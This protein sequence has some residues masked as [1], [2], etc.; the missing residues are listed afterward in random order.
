MGTIF[1]NKPMQKGFHQKAIYT[2][3]WVAGLYFYTFVVN[4]K[5][6]TTSK[7]IK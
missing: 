7:L 4:G 6:V 5:K 2:S 1:L 3:Q